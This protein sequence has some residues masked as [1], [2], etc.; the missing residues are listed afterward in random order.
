MPRNSNGDYSLP[1]GNPVVTGTTISSTWANTTLAD[2]GNALTDSL[3]RSGDGSMLGPLLLDDGAIGAPALSWGNETTSGL[4]RA[5]AGDFR[6]SISGADRIQITSS[7]VRVS[8]GTQA[9]PAL[10]FV[11]DTDTGFYR[12][13][14]NNLGLSIGSSKVLDVGPSLYAWGTDLNG[15]VSLSVLNTNTGGGAI[16]RIVVGIT[17]SGNCALVGTPVAYGPYLSGSPAGIQQVTLHTGL[18]TPII[19]GTNDVAR[20]IV[21]QTGDNVIFRP[22]IYGADGSSGAPG[23]SFESDPD[24]GFFRGGVNDLRIVAG[25]VTGITFT[26]S[27]IQSLAIDGLVGSPSYSFL[28]DPDTG[29]YRDSANSTSFTAGGAVVARFR[30]TGIF[31]VPQYLSPD[32][33]GALPSYSFASDADTGMFLGLAGRLDFS[34]D[35][36]TCLQFD[37]TTM[38]IGAGSGYA[39]Q[40]FCL[41]SATANVGGVAPP[42]TVAGYLAVNINGT[43]RKIP[44]YAN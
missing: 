3:S 21:H 8:D 37:D 36:T 10:S 38:A 41:T 43:A 16:G 17:G 14:S 11:S 12:I 24:T 34:A 9:L 5:G 13:G 40:F 22:P 7:G 42:A 30:S 33:S 4:Y 2:I 1:A 44:Y 31:S 35:G 19:I 23:Y 18:V 15:L 27:G 6:Y 29:L 28:S 20:I 25:G 32:G 39:I 26:T